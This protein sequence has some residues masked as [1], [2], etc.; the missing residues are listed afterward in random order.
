M[1][2][3]PDQPPLYPPLPQPPAKPP[4]DW[5]LYME[6]SSMAAFVLP[7]LGNI[8]G[9]L[10]LWLVTKENDPVADAEGKKVLNFNISWSLWTLA[11][12]GLGFFA[13]LVIAIIAIIKAANNQPFRHPLT[14]QFLK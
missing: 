11:T 10:I 12:C 1:T 14:I 7:V 2:M 13:W 5:R 9:P 8:L 3:N 4:T 6:L